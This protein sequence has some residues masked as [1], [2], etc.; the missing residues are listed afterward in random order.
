MTATRVCAEGARRRGLPPVRGERREQAGEVLAEITR[1]AAVVGVGE[2]PPER[3]GRPPPPRRF[4][5]GEGV[6]GVGVEPRVGDRSRRR[7]G[8]S[9]AP[10]RRSGRRG[11]GA[12]R[13][14]RRRWGAVVRE[15]FGERLHLLHEGA[16][17]RWC[18]RGRGRAEEP[19]GRNLL[20]DEA[21]E[22]AI[23]FDLRG[24]A[25]EAAGELLAGRADVRRGHHQL[26]R[27]GQ[28]GG[29]RRRR[30]RGAAPS[31]TTWASGRAGE[32][33]GR[34][35]P[36]RADDTA[37]RFSPRGRRSCGRRSRGRRCRCGRRGRGL[38]RLAQGEGSRGE[39]SASTTL[40]S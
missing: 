12:R 6:A 5:A 29:A 17:G 28:G 21:V 34:G 11:R 32:G 23:P 4:R 37:G 31:T 22:L 33:S 7:G 35:G 3:E 8:S 25:T 20:A 27:R 24:R 10:G 9:R 39:G 2:G 36:S 19:R 13:R 18:R 16:G 38:S 14:V 1:H 15:V 40:G 30:R 26:A